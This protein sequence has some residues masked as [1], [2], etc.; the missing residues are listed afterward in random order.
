MAAGADGLAGA[1]EAAAPKISKGLSTMTPRSLVP[2][3]PAK[4]RPV[5]KIKTMDN[6]LFIIGRRLRL[7][8]RGVKSKPGWTAERNE[9]EL[10][11]RALSNDWVGAPGRFRLN[12][13]PIPF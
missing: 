5:A 1:R 12:A 2:E 9:Q 10:Q 3:Q 13:W 4:M 11:K 7:I 6:S 8:V